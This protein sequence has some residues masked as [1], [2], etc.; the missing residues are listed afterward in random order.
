MDAAA[1]AD[2][3][4]SADQFVATATSGPW[5]AFKANGAVDPAAEVFLRGLYADASP[6][7]LADLSL[8]DLTA[9][10]HDFWRWR[11]ER[12]VDEQ[13]VRVRRG[14]GAGGRELDRDILEIV[15]PD[16]PFLVDSVMGELA[17]EGITARGRSG[18]GI[19]WT[20]VWTEGRKI[21]SIGL[22]V[23]QGVTKHGFAVNVDNSLEPFGWIVPCGLPEVQMTSVAV[24]A[25]GPGPHLPCFR[26]RMA[27]RFA[28]AHG[29]R[30]RLV[31]R[32]R[33]EAALADAPALA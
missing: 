17:D 10:G 6:D 33:L 29:A 19:A 25:P 1:R 27:W 32:A 16:M 30:Q 21:A 18:E 20:G 26:K 12:K 13:L 3:S 9:L 24:E 5:P 2:I 14:F 7:E 22:H 8:E 28:E 23:S 15:G 31:S 4:P 11:S